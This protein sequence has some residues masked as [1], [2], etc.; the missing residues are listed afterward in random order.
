MLKHKSNY[1]NP[2]IPLGS[3]DGKR[4]K[5]L[6]R[7]A[8][9]N[10][11]TADEVELL[12]DLGFR[13][14]SFEDVYTECDFDEMK[15]KLMAYKESQG[16]FQIPKKYELDPE[17]GAWVT[18]VRRLYKSNEL[19][20]DEVDKMNEI[21]FEWISSRKCGSSFMTRYRE[22]QELLNNATVSGLDAS[23]VVDDE[24]DMKKWIHAQKCAFESGKLSESRISCMNDL[25]VD[26]RH[27]SL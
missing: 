12:T 2:N 10:K 26:W 4:C 8:F 14:S 13:W 21:Q 1:G 18:M 5:T 6:R 24:L 9:Q 27:I 19:P 16:T 22:I 25:G 23:K 17:L 20:K 11:L 15:S 7:L 3:E